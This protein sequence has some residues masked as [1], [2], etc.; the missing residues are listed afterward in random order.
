MASAG[1]DVWQITLQDIAAAARVPQE[2]WAIFLAAVG[3]P[4]CVEA[5]AS[6]HLDEWVAAVEKFQVSA[7]CGMRSQFLNPTA[8]SETSS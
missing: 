3:G 6:V 7:D 5:A 1:Q 4:Q 2:Q 8:S